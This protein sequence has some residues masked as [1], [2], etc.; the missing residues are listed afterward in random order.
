[1]DV[2]LTQEFRKF[3]ARF[4]GPINCGEFKMDVVIGMF[5]RIPSFIKEF[6]ILS[7]ARDMDETK[8]NWQQIG[9]EMLQKA[10]KGDK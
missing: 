4:V 7:A 1:L 2:K 3:F 6:A 8:Q 9:M 5:T 10:K